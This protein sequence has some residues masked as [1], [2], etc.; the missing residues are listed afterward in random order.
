MGRRAA[1][2]ALLLLSAC[3]GAEGVTTTGVHGGS[4][5]PLAP[6]WSAE[7]TLVRAVA[8][9]AGPEEAARIE[10]R[11]APWMRAVDGLIDRRPVSVSVVVGGDR[12][13]GH[14]AG[15][16]RAPASN[17]KLL[18]SMAALDRLGPGFRIATEAAIRDRM[19]DG[20]V[21][22]DLFLVGHGDPETGADDIHRLAVRLRDAGLTRVDGSIVG[23]TSAFLRDREAPGWHRIALAYIGLPTALSFDGNVDANGYVFD[24]ERR[25]AAALTAELRAIGVH[26]DGEARVGAAPGGL[27]T[28][29]TVRS[30]PLEEILTRQNVSS[31][32]LDAETLSK[33]LA[34]E[35]LGRPGSIA[36]GAAVIESWADDHGA[37][38]TLHDACGLSYRD[39]VSAGALAALLDDARRRPWGDELRA[40]LAA[41]G[42]GTLSGRLSGLP[43]RA[44]TGTLI[45]EVS[46]LSGYV[47]LRDGRWASFSILS[48]LP[49][50]EAVALEDSIVR[51]I[52]TNA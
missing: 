29:A 50:D 15:V 19:H 22:G 38:A 2:C 48:Q 51:A 14:L 18:L 7:P 35:V 32:N 26:V 42:E 1:A 37:E 30:A 9:G 8:H 17:E 28:I 13:Y 3:S 46:A 40:S 39:R 6:G 16:P 24:P 47:R 11:P 23:D 36:D 25:A 52:A 34:T 4:L 44:K 27:R 12:V 43:V 33:L 41:P 45:G 5:G 31:D 20:V 49:K 10:V 21:G